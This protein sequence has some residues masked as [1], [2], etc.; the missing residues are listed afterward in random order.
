VIL[1]VDLKFTPLV[2][3]VQQY[4]STKLEVSTALL[5]RADGQMDGQTDEVQHLMWPATKGL[6]IISD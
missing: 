4:V 5:F 1:T 6:I 3:L 2:T